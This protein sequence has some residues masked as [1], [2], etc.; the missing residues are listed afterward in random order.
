MRRKLNFV[1]AVL[2]FLGILFVLDTV[3]HHSRSTA[4]PYVVGGFA[5]STVCL[6]ATREREWLDVFLT[7]IAG[8]LTLFAAATTTAVRQ[9]HRS[10]L[11]FWGF[12]SSAVVLILTYP[13]EAGSVRSDCSNRG[14][15]DI[16][17][18]GCIPAQLIA[19]PDSMTVVHSHRR[20][21][22]LRMG[23]EN[24]PSGSMSAIAMSPQPHESVFCA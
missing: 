11:L 4:W 7:A 1:L 3:A 13:E 9:H 19:L 23:I 17:G 22:A 24:G 15:S 12:A 10:W 20:F 14:V 16:A 2:A 21:H 5:F 6:V 8:L 18:G